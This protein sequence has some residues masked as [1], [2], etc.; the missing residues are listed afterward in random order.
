MRLFA[1]FL[2]IGFFGPSAVGRAEPLEQPTIMATLK[3]ERERDGECSEIH[4]GVPAGQPS[5]TMSGLCHGWAATSCYDKLLIL[6]NGVIEDQAQV[7][8]TDQNRAID[9]V[10]L[11]DLALR[12]RWPGHEHLHLQFGAAS[13]DGDSLKLRVTGS[14]LKA[15]TEGS[16]SSFKGL[17]Q[18]R[19]PSNH[20]ITLKSDD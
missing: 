4:G 9:L 18:I 1:L 13:C 16:A 8:F 19:S 10:K 20:R 15:K 3:I 6:G 5:L 7:L 17:I 12:R 14:H 2:V 11:V